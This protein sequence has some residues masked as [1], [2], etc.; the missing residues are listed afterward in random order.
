MVGAAHG[1]VAKVKELASARPALARATW[2]WGYGDWESALGAASHVG[3]KEI[4]A[5]LLDNGAH[6]TIFSAAMLGQTD[7]VRGFIAARLVFSVP[8]VRTGSRCSPT[9]VPERTLKW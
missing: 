7:A 3:N 5:I 1:N 6:P 2:D 9:R 4:A 8:A